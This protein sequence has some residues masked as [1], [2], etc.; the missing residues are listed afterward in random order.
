MLLEYS[1]GMVASLRKDLQ[2]NYLR[3]ASEVSQYVDDGAKMMIRN[4]WLEQPPQAINHKT[5]A[6]V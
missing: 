4:G 3:L 2:A 5:L 6:N 1:A